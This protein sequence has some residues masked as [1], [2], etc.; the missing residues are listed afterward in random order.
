[1]LKGALMGTIQCPGCQAEI[2]VEVE[3]DNGWLE[4]TR[5]VWCPCGAELDVT[6]HLEV[7]VRLR[8]GG[9]TG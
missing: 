2:F 8:P 6:T 4:S 1:M 3:A 7:L 5:Q 9:P